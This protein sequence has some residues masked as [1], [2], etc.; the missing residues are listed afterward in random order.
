MRISRFGLLLLFLLAAHLLYAPAWQA[1][2]TRDVTGW[3]ASLHTKTFPD[4]LLRRGL[5]VESLY[6][7]TQWMLWAWWKIFGIHPLPWHLLMGSLHAACAWG[8]A[9]FYGHIF[10]KKNTGI[11]AGLFFLLSPYATEAVVWE[12]GYH[13]LQGMALLLA[14]LF[15]LLRYLE[16]GK[17]RWVAL[18]L[19]AFLPTIFALETFY[20][21][22]VYAALIIVYF[23]KNPR[24]RKAFFFFVLPMLALCGVQYALFR[25][26][27][28]EPVPHIKTLTL[29]RLSD[30]L[31]K[32]AKYI[33]HL[34]FFGRYW[35]ESLREKIYEA[36]NSWAFLLTFYPAQLTLLV[37]N[38]RALRRFPENPAFVPATFGLAALLLVMPLYFQQAG[39]VDFDR[40][41]YFM[42]PA[43]GAL[44]GLYFRKKAVRAG[45]LALS[46]GLLFYTNLLWRQSDAKSRE[47]LAQIPDFGDGKPT[48]LLNIPN[49]LRSVPM[50]GQTREGEAALMRHTVLQKPLSGT[51]LEPSAC[52]LHSIEDLAVEIHWQNA[53]TLE[54]TQPR[55]GGWWEG[56]VLS[57]DW[58]N[59]LFAVRFFP[60]KRA[61]VL[62]LKSPPEHFRLL[63]WSGSRWVEIP[64]TCQVR[65]RF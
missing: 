64:P 6:P 46:A 37:R 65:V 51:V 17:R 49:A 2:W 13:Y 36:L 56:G 7:F 5:G 23:R 52:N 8:W 1:G 39:L 41:A 18:G 61:Y 16:S 35:P 62:M 60:E 3:I 33:F 22:P 44:L 26:L 29:R 12:A 25:W 19:L 34:F 48:V 4:Y 30:Y 24:T 38:R 43:V 9:L 47:M 57:A 14:T 40:Y 54:V 11:F 28:S 15:C 58:E 10:R 32:P 63:R 27:Y 42:L 31:R 55:G 21:T 20:L 59:D 53:Q 45:I 50:I